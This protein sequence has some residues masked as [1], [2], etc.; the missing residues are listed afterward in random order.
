[1]KYYLSTQHEVMVRTDAD[2]N[3]AFIKRDEREFPSDPENPI[4]NDAIIEGN[5]ISE[6][7]YGTSL[8]EG[9]EIEETP[10]EEEDE[11]MPS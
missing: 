7:Q 5:I 8:E 10:L 9:A 1:M 6:E 2:R 3:E 11:E 4:V